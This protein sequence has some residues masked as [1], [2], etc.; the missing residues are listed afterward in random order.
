MRRLAFFLVVFVSSFALLNARA[1][2]YKHGSILSPEGC[3]VSFTVY[4][5][6]TSSYI[7]VEIRSNRMTF[8]P[9]AKMLLKTTKGDILDLKGELLATD[10]VTDFWKNELLGYDDNTIIARARFV[11]NEDQIEKLKDGIIK[12]RL[13]TM[14]SI[15]EHEFEKDNIGYAL[16]QEFKKL[17]AD[18]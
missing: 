5:N 17:N 3:K 10:Q 16:Y 11:I 15:H 13:M 12:I 6:D 14:P 8:S 18:F 4:S 7:M 9:D 2:R 1:I